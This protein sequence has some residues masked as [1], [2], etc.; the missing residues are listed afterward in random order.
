MLESGS[1]ALQDRLEGEQ[2]Q[3]IL[4]DPPVQMLHGQEMKELEAWTLDA[5]CGDDAVAAVCRVWTVDLW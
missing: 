1:Q 5:K 2:L 4:Q 3:D